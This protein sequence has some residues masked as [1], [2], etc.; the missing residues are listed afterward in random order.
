M[1]SPDKLLKIV[2]TDNGS[3]KAMTGRIVHEDDFFF[4]IERENSNVEMLGKKAI[5]RIK[6]LEDSK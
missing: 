4:F 5:I 6:E 2:Y 3:D 1:I